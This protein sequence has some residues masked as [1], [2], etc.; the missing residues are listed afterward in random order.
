MGKCLVPSSRHL[1]P[2]PFAASSSE[3]TA[4]QACFCPRCWW[5]SIFM[6]EEPVLGA[7]SLFLQIILADNFG[8][9]PLQTHPFHW[10]LPCDPG[11]HRVHSACGL[12]HTRT[13]KAPGNR[14]QNSFHAPQPPRSLTIPN[15]HPSTA[16]QHPCWPPSCMDQSR[17][18]GY[19]MGSVVLPK[20]IKTHTNTLAKPLG[21]QSQR[22][23]PRS[24]SSEGPKLSDLNN[25]SR[26]GGLC[27]ET[28]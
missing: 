12:I 15:P 1:L 28:T 4:E 20:V 19:K 3:L 11:S 26:Q 21:L 18:Y 9:C 27:E 17:K 23:L 13:S 5:S 7:T 10:S 24:M 8:W 25:M 22:G 2:P 6:S 14:A 16:P